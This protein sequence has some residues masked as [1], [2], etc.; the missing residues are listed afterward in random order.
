[1]DLRS[2]RG[3]GLPSAYLLPW[4]KW[5]LGYQ[6]VAADVGSWGKARSGRGWG[7]LEEEA[8]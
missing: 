7:R 4:E 8:L 6:G 5:S 2:G 3:V 1:M